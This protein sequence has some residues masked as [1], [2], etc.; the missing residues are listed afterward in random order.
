MMMQFVESLADET[1][2]LKRRPQQGLI[3]SRRGRP[4]KAFDF[5]AEK[6]RLGIINGKRGQKSFQHGP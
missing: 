4:R 1:Q 5:R 2:V 3:E 6:R